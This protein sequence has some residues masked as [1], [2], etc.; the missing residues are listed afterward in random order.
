MRHLSTRKPIIFS[1]DS[2]LYSLQLNM[3]LILD[4]SRRVKLLFSHDT[5]IEPDHLKTCLKSIHIRNS[6]VRIQIY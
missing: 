4:R 5:Q 2:F 1:L 3:S 6:Y